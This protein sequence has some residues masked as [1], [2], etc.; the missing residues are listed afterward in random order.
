MTAVESENKSTPVA[1]YSD[2]A[3]VGLFAAL[4]VYV[5]NLRNQR[6]GAVFSCI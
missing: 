2:T 5:E 3:H 4:V 1:N 6:S